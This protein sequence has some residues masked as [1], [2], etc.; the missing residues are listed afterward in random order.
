MVMT[1]DNSPSSLELLMMLDELDSSW[2]ARKGGERTVK[3]RDGD[4][5]RV[6]IAIIGG[7]NEH[8]HRLSRAISL[9]HRNDLEFESHALVREAF[10]CGVTAQWVGHNALAPS[11]LA[12]E[13]TRTRK[14]TKR[15]MAKSST[16]IFADN[17]AAIVV[18][19]PPPLG[20]TLKDR[21]RNFAR[22]CKDFAPDGND[23]YLL[24]R[25]LSDSSHASFAVIDHNTSIDPKTGRLSLLRQPDHG[26]RP[27]FLLWIT[28]SAVI[29]T[30]TAMNY[31]ERD[32]VRR[33]EL[34]AMARKAHTVPELTL[35]DEAKFKADRALA[36][37]RRAAKSRD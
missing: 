24:Y 11:A 28:I 3:H 30:D 20:E 29:W 18:D 27:E 7:F 37:A 32:K 13:Y 23:L 16:R 5:S 15:D 14:A 25:V 34:R 10:E 22:L 1:M 9:L 8:V 35:T 36:K 31:L 17:A 4:T 19:D 12:A 33:D 26:M 2:E 21:A 6:R